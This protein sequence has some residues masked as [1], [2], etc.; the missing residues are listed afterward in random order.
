MVPLSSTPC[1]SILL[2]LQMKPPMSP[3]LTALVIVI[4][5]VLVWR[6]FFLPPLLSFV[7]LSSPLCWVIGEDCLPLALVLRPPGVRDSSSALIRANYHFLEVRGESCETHTHFLW[8]SF[9]FLLSY[10]NT[11]S[12][13]Q[14]YTHTYILSLPLPL[15]ITHTQ[16]S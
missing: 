5:M 1:P 8:L 14:T 12:L 3:P 11:H 2:R 6:C 15:P 16:R 10:P 7:W 4:R 9:T 13:S